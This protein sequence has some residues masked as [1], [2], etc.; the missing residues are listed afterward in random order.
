MKGGKSLINFGAE[1]QERD[2]KVVVVQFVRVV[3]GV[4]D[5]DGVDLDLS[6]RQLDLPRYPDTRQ[7]A[8]PSLRHTLPM[9]MPMPHQ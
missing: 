5:G 7:A 4:G 3:V 1:Q 2:W 6:C 9:P 8:R